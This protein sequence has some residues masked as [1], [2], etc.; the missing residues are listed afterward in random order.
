[1]ERKEVGGSTSS[2]QST[3][4]FHDLLPVD[5]ALAPGP[6]APLVPELEPERE[7]GVDDGEESKVSFA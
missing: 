7:V 1:M 6:G 3:M 2:S 4:D 5:G